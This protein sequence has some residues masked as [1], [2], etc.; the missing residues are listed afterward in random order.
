MNCPICKSS[1]IQK[2]YI[3]YDDRHG[4]PGEFQS[5]L[6][7][8]C[9]HHFLDISFS[10]EEI[11]TLYTSYYPRRT[12]NI[13]NFKPV[14]EPKGFFAWLNGEKR[15]AYC[16]VPPQVR[17]LDIGCGFGETLAYHSARGCDAY[18]VEA[19]ENAKRTAERF[20]LNIQIGLFDASNYPEEYF[21]YITMDQV[22]EHLND[23]ITSLSDISR[24]LKRG[25]TLIISTP[26]A[27]GWG[28]KLF[29]RKWIQWHAPYHLHMF[30]KQS[31]VEA[32]QKTGFVIQRIQTITSS[33]WLYYQLVH[34]I[35]YPT[36]GVPSI[37][38]SMQKPNAWGLKKITFRRIIK[39]L[40]LAKL[41]HCLTRF[42]DLLNK[43]DGIL[44]FLTKQ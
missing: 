30:S 39:I 37:Y 10:P 12:L 14:P 4:Y 38:W 1:I 18:G 2:K 42:F 29:K 31:M 32:A 24:V 28:R 8:H 44:I 15:S 13:D 22:I 41:T 11:T 33:E 35:S 36:M 7:T 5:L 25:G 3:L 17:I 21:D 27:D 40:H 20:N 26:N 19:D 23:P 9:G 16:W 43:G 34:L 6:C